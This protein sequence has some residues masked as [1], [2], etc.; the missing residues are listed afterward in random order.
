MIFRYIY[1]YISQQSTGFQGATKNLQRWPTT[2]PVHPKRR[3]VPSKS[4]LPWR[5]HRKR[6]PCPEEAGTPAPAWPCRSNGGAAPMEPL[7]IS[8][9]LIRVPRKLMGNLEEIADHGYHAGGISVFWKPISS[10][11][12]N[13]STSTFQPARKDSLETSGSSGYWTWDAAQKFPMSLW[14]SQRHLGHVT[15]RART[16]PSW[17][18]LSPAPPRAANRRSCDLLTYGYG[19]KLGTPKLWMVNTRLTSVVP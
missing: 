13:S 16:W 17:K 2:H 9:F 3:W 6:P 5:P 10:I 7:K 11:E 8:P 12:E 14:Q 19:S 4:S 1:I 18:C 15:L